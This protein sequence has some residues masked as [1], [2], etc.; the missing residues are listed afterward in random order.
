MLIYTPS[1]ESFKKCEKILAELKKHQYGTTFLFPV[2]VE[3]YAQ[4]IKEPMDLSTVEKKLKSGAYA[5]TKDFIHDVRLIWNNAWSYNQP[6]SNIFIATTE[7]SNFFEKLITDLG[8]A[9][10]SASAI[11][12]ILELKKQVSKVTGAIKKMAG[13]SHSKATPSHKNLTNKPISL[14]EKAALKSNIMKLPQ[15]KIGGIVDIIKNSV[16][17]SQNTETLEFDIDSL[18]PQCCRELEAY[19]KKVLQIGQKPKK[20]PTNKQKIPKAMPQESVN[21][22]LLKLRNSS[23]HHYHC[24]CP[25]YLKLIKFLKHLKYMSQKNKLGKVR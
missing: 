3:G 15:D 19:V 20:K 12:E 1:I 7:I 22:V 2:D 9:P 8:E 5:S 13:T 24:L 18:P 23:S 10:L 4:I 11:N 21:T 25:T 16:D 14:Q 17:V 6:G